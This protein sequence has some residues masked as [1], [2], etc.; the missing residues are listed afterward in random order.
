MEEFQEK[1]EEKKKK[2]GKP[3]MSYPNRL[4][5]ALEGIYEDEEATRSEKLQAVQLSLETLAIRPVP[6]RKSD[7]D[8]ALEKMLGFGPKKRGSPKTLPE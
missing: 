2:K 1:P 4:L 7:K 5:R 8:K 6:K 3:G